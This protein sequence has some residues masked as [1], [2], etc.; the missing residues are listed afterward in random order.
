MPLSLT[1][2]RD[3]EDEAARVVGAWIAY[4]P[5]PLAERSVMLARML[6][7]NAAPLVAEGSALAGISRGLHNLV[8]EALRGEIS[9]GCAGEAQVVIHVR[10]T[11]CELYIKNLEAWREEARTA[12][13]R[14]CRQSGGMVTR[15]WRD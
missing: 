1:R 9:W 6:V 7:D 14:D 12:L 4:P 10:L 5:P 3:V 13:R 2:T 8:V 15:C 11:L